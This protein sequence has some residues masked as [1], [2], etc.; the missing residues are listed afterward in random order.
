[1]LLRPTADRAMTRA[2]VQLI[3]NVTRAHA[4]NSPQLLLV[5]IPLAERNAPQTTRAIGR[6]TWRPK[7]EPT[8]GPVPGGP[9]PGG[10]VPG[11]T[12]HGGAGGTARTTTRT[13]VCAADGCNTQLA[14]RRTQLATCR[15]QLATRH[16][17]LA[18][19]H[20]Q[21]AT[22]HTQLATRHT[23]LATHT[24]QATHAISCQLMQN[25]PQ[26][27]A[28]HRARPAHICTGTGSPAA[29]SAPGLGSPRPHLHRD[30]AHP[31]QHLFWSV[32]WNAVSG[33]L[34]SR[35]AF[36]LLH[37]RSAF[38]LLH[39]RSAFALLHSLTSA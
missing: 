17:Q 19:R 14:T 9:V 7:A 33:L 16:T 3:Q 34:H 2:A 39:S 12:G 8:G 30:W 27:A 10:P 32:L 21:L 23:Q 37:S 36:A 24:L 13:T 38:A 29:I 6:T 35:S 11:G 31:R 15:T 18:T 25:P 26:P 22:R 20:T 28:L 1:M 4:I 5:I